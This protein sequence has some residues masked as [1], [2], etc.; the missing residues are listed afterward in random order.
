MLP[1]IAYRAFGPEVEYANIYMHSQNITEIKTRDIL[2]L[3]TSIFITYTALPTIGGRE[4]HSHVLY[5]S[6]DWPTLLRNF[7]LKAIL[8]QRTLWMRLKGSNLP[9]GSRNTPTGSACYSAGIGFYFASGKLSV[10][11]GG[12]SQDNVPRHS[13]R[14]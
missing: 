6:W 10:F 3:K 1:A 5:W 14:P 9:D 2:I 7:A 13:K 11:G 8:P 12:G 4:L